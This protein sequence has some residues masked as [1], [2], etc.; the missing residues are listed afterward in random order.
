MPEDA[1]VHY[2]VTVRPERNE[3]LVKARFRGTFAKCDR[4][5]I[6]TPT[7]VPG[8]YN[9]MQFAR[10]I[11]WVEAV[12]TASGDPLEVHREGWTGFRVIDP[13]GDVT[14]NYRAYAFEPEF[15]EPSG[16]L[17]S[18]YAV[19]LGNRYL[20]TK[21]HLGPCQ[22]SYDL[23]AG[24]QGTIHHPS[25][26]TKVD[27]NTW[28]YPSYEVLLDTPVAMGQFD[29]RTR[30]VEGV[31]FYFVFVDQS[32]GYEA[33][34]EGFVDKI[35]RVTKFF[36]NMFGSFPFSDYTFVLSCNPQ[37]EWGLEHLTSTMCGLGADVF[38]DEGQYKI[39]V[40]VCAHELFHAWNVRR[41][42]PEP[43]LEL[44]HKLDSGSFTEGLWV[45]EGFTRFY[46][47]LSCT[48]TGVYSPAEFFSNIVGYYEHLTLV[49]AYERVTALDSSLATYLNHN[50]KYPG[51]V[52]NCID[53]YD[54]G[55]LIAFGLD[56]SLRLGTENQ[57]LNTA[58][59]TFFHEYVHWPPVD[60]DQVGYTTA[61]VLVFFDGILPGLGAQLEREVLHP[62]GLSTENILQALGFNLVREQA[63]YLGLVFTS[64]LSVIYNLLDDAP[65]GNCGLAPG[66][67]VTSV[68]GY[69]RTDAG[70]R[71]A[72]GHDQ[73]VTLG[74]TRGHRELNFTI[75]PGKR[76]VIAQLI[77]Q[78]DEIQSARLSEWFNQP[79]ALEA[80]QQI[81]LDFYENFHG[82]E[83]V[84]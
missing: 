22:V 30:T 32:V 31:E 60:P 35:A 70:L 79:F 76:D 75:M 66:D 53:Y 20:Y 5:V 29:T 11:F 10:D 46:E 42:R 33:R 7:W 57:N 23:P 73:P 28:E 18:T 25:G 67:V 56:A 82:I 69:A 1:A 64:G 58:F 45:A 83:T 61:Q 19:L 26:A 24:W 65:A 16:I 41:L 36:H 6:E 12:D 13:T 47:F 59:A 50:P 55:M 68:N 15:G 84:L 21:G 3:L 27:N 78:G 72:A 44:Q 77:W 40:R 71:W 37:N 9:F 63:N 4:L 34:V 80:G 51:R 62:G 43:L 48:V 52:N 8:N 2:S 39:G 38:S 74:V 54:K 14:V 17:D 81:P 49:P